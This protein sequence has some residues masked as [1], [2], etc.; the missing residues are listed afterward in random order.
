MLLTKSVLIHGVNISQY[1]KR[2]EII[3]IF[4]NMC[5]FL[6][7]IACPRAMVYV[8]STKCKGKEKDVLC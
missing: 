7:T 4:L 8:I 1:E 6:L 2:Q 5:L 3:F